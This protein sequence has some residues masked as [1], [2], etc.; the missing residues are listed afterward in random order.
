MSL[1]NASLKRPVWKGANGSLTQLQTELASLR[2]DCRVAE[3]WEAVEALSTRIRDT[4][5]LISRRTDE[6]RSEVLGV[7]R[8]P[9][10]EVLERVTEED[11]AL[12]EQQRRN[13]LLTALRD[14]GLH[15][16]EHPTYHSLLHNFTSWRFD[17]RGPSCWMEVVAMIEA[18]G[19]LK[20]A[21][22]ERRVR[23]SMKALLVDRL[24]NRAIDWY[25]EHGSPWV[26][27][28]A[29]VYSELRLCA[30]AEI[31]DGVPVRR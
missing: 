13:K 6:R 22:K 10:N 20:R 16:P 15:Q 24:H 18:F 2:A 3:T 17:T 29:D 27:T 26:P 12:T 31:R 30:Q 14:A 25:G 19:G 1:S 23:R 8:R 9:L 11:A 28:E 4:V 21:G 7:V 5:D